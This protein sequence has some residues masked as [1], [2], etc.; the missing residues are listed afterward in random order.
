ML[1]GSA[2]ELE[3]SQLSVSR[4]IHKIINALFRLHIAQQ[5][6]KFPLDKWQLHKGGGDGFLTL[7]IT[8]TH[9]TYI[10]A[11]RTRKLI[12]SNHPITKIFNVFIFLAVRVAVWLFLEIL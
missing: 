7:N 9:T 4:I 12:T 3:I 8:H 1:S 10:F 6:I 2:D 5:F 11:V